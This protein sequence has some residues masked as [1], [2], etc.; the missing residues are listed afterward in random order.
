MA[1]ILANGEICWDNDIVPNGYNARALSPP[2]F[3]DIRVADDFVVP[4]GEVFRIVDFHVRVIEEATWIPGDVQRTYI[5]SDAGGQPGNEILA[6]DT[7]FDREFAG[8]FF[9]RDAYDYWVKFDDPI[10]LNSGPYWIGF[11]QPQG[12]GA[13]TNYWLTSN[14]GQGTGR[15]GWKSLDNGNTWQDEG[16]DWHHA[17]VITCA[18]PGA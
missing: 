18:P 7:G 12:G 6:V 17:F 11:K 9:D 10:I 2:G 5:Y 8:Q 3:P 13:A 16:P 4:A 15:T 14:G 1:S